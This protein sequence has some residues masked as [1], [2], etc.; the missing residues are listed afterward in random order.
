MQARCKPWRWLML[1]NLEHSTS[2]LNFVPCAP[3]GN[4]RVRERGVGKVDRHGIIEHPAHP[5]RRHSPT[6]QPTVR[7]A[8]RR[9]LQ[10][11]ELFDGLPRRAARAFINFVPHGYEAEGPRQVEP[12]RLEVGS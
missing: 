5:G 4:E 2:R 1:P 11:N 12:A 3:S 6:V 7:P 8:P 10:S 9:R